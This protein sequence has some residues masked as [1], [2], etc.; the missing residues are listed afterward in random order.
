MLVE[1]GQTVYIEYS[2]VSLRAAGSV[3]FD[4]VLLSVGLY[5]CVGMLSVWDWD[6]VN[7]S[8]FFYKNMFSLFNMK[9]LILSG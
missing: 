8:S 5:L 7:Y 6:L 3:G 2:V 4:V 1:E 9:S